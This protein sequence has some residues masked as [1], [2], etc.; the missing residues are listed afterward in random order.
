VSDGELENTSLSAFVQSPERRATGYKLAD[1]GHDTRAIQHFLG[2]TNIVQTRRYP[3][4]APD[5]FKMFWR[6]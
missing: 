2:H 4:L 5:R 1:D 3:N 6:D